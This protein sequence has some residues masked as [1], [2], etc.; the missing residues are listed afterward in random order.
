MLPGPGK[1]VLS[2][3]VSG[4]A[5]HDSVAAAAWAQQLP[6]GP[7]RDRAIQTVVSTLADKDPSA[8]LDFMQN[9]PSG[10]NRQSLYWP[11]FNRWATTDPVERRQY[12]REAEGRIVRQV[13]LL[14]AKAARL[15]VMIDEAQAR[16]ARVRGHLVELEDAPAETIGEAAR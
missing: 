1:G 12:L 8:A 7:V 6:A 9:L 3:A 4:W 15:A 13:A 10:R 5:E 14:D 11:I 2:G 16:L